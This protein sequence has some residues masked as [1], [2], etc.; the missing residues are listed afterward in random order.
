MEN[1]DLTQAIFDAKVAEIKQNGGVRLSVRFKLRDGADIFLA[2]TDGKFKGLAISE[3][4]VDVTTHGAENEIPEHGTT[5]NKYYTPYTTECVPL[6]EII[7]YHFAYEKVTRS[8]DI[9]NV[10]TTS[11]E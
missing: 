7:S 3:T 2:A 9:S 10:T 1:T 5:K 8:E 11:N 6:S 4:S